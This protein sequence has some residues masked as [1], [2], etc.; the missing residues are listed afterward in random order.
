MKDLPNKPFRFRYRKHVTLGADYHVSVG[1]EQHKYSVP[2]KYVSLPVT[3][4][5]DMDTVEIYHNNERIAI[6]QRSFENFSIQQRRLICPPIIWLGSV[7]R[8]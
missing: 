6:H 4:L 1:H 2:Y 8:N 5:W 3:V 7:L